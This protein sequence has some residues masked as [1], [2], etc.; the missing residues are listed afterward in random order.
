MGRGINTPAFGI[1]AALVVG[2]VVTGARAAPENWKVYSYPD[3]GFSAELPSDPAVTRSSL[4]TSKDP[5]P[6]ASVTVEDMRTL[7]SFKLIAPK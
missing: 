3:L 5:R 2:L 6:V 4:D 7:S 1:L